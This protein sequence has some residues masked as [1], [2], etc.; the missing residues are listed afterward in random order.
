MRRRTSFMPLGGVYI[1]EAI[2]ENCGSSSK[3]LKIKLPYQSTPL[4]STY[5]KAV[6]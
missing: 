1:N 4:L 3:K 6:K 2:M 5:P